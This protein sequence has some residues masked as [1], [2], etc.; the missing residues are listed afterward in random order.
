[1]IMPPLNT[2]SAVR[3]SIVVA[4]PHITTIAARAPEQVARADAAPP[5]G[6]CRAAPDCGSGW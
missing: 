3:K 2:P 5:S 6:R 4:V 1:M